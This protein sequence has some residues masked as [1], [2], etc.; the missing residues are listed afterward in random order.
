MA[1]E[2]EPRKRAN[3][4]V[5]ALGTALG[6]VIGAS[7]LLSTALAVHEQP[8][9]PFELDGDP[10]KTTS[11][12]DW[13][14]VFNLPTPYPTTRG[15]PVAG[16]GETFVADGATLAGGKE[17]SAWQGSNK[18]IDLIGTW[19]YKASKVTPDKDNITNAYAKAYEVPG[20]P[21]GDFPNHPAGT[22]SH[23]VIY[24]G[25]DRFANNGDAALGFWFFKSNVGLKAPGAG[26]VGTFS[27]E[28]EE[29]D[30]L[31]QVDFVS[32]GSSSEVQIFKWVG[33]GGDFGALEEIKFDSSNGAEVCTD[34][35]TACA[36]TNESTQ[37]SPWAYTPKSGTNN[38]FP[39]ESFFEAGIDVTAL[40]GEVCFSS[41][42]AETRSS[43]SE[44]AELKDF[45]LG[46]FDLCSVDV[47]KVCNAE[48]G[49]SPVF[50]PDDETF[51][52]KHTVTITN[53]GFGTLYDVALRDDKVDTDK[54]CSIT[55]ITGD[56][57]G[58]P[59]VGTGILFPDN[60]TFVAVADRLDAHDSMT[61][62]MLCITDVNAFVNGVTVESSA[63]DG[64][65]TDVVDTDLETQAQ[66]NVCL[67]EFD[68]GLKL[69][70][71]CQGDPGT[72][73]NPNTEFE[74]G[75]DSVVLDPN[76][77]FAPQVCVDVT[78]SSTTSNQKMVI[79]SWDDDQMGSLLPAGGLTL[80][81]L[82]SYVVSR[83]YTPT[84]PDNDETEP[85]LVTYT[86]TVTA[87]G[88][89]KQNNATANA[90][91]ASATCK[92]C[93]TCPDCDP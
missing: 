83:C 30:I 80:D 41:F 84:A 14:N 7:A 79:D 31:V 19:E 17:L 81:P 68:T 65:D 36:I 48:A 25:A 55:A 61:I 69:T 60:E 74:P 59:T 4:P 67:A 18:D 2:K 82:G 34:D 88:H 75:D 11:D 71:F 9:S 24:F 29:G 32:G 53:D 52:T 90:L 3:W 85:G 87:S 37:P 10:T 92:L 38:N 39:N 43:H 35:D 5:A 72:N 73:E 47:E 86:D 62:T 57:V 51:Q 66:A 49:V 91:P 15:T 70:K 56:G 20:F 22:H 46:D 40:V 50:D 44:T 93:P 54:V 23:L 26:G 42:M 78:I 76:N 58:T 12:D 21:G 27:G 45:A 63:T 16:D 13:N 6:A 1:I 77:G 33:S 28:H 8:A 89:G 64:G